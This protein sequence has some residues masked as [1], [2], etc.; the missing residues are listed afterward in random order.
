LLIKAKPR[1]PNPKLRIH[2]LKTQEPLCGVG[3]ALLLTTNP[4]ME[5]EVR[6]E[7]QSLCPN[8]NAG[9]RISRD[10]SWGFLLQTSLQIT[11]TESLMLSKHL[12]VEMWIATLPGY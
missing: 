5:R 2:Q 8:L 4:G 11:L 10:F 9:N 1:I 3:D 12:L 6:R 7:V